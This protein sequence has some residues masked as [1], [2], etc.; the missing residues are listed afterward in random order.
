MVIITVDGTVGGKKTVG[1]NTGETG[2]ILVG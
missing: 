2:K 1:T